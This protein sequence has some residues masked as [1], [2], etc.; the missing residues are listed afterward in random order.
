[1]HYL[2]V[3]ADAAALS[4]SNTN[5]FVVVEGTVHHPKEWYILCEKRMATYKISAE[6][7]L[8]TFN[9]HPDFYLLSFCQ[10]EYN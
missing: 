2:W 9:Y 1:M 3:P 7:N 8:H 4:R 5:P 10:L 6:K